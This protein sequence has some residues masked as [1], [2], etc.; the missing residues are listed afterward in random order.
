M[1][2]ARVETYR[3]RCA[4]ERYAPCPPSINGLAYMQPS[5][6]AIEGTT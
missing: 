3:K 2:E 6:I 1:N 5:R 4:S